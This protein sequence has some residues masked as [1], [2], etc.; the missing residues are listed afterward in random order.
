MYQEEEEGQEKQW[1]LLYHDFD[2]VDYV[3]IDVI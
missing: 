2:V 1:N 3:S